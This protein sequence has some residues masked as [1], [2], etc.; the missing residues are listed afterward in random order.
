MAD[1]QV[2]PTTPPS[3]DTENPDAYPVI[4]LGTP[5]RDPVQI[6]LADDDS[7]SDETS[8]DGSFS[9]YSV[10]DNSVSV[11][12]HAPQP[13][14]TSHNSPSVLADREIPDS[15][16]ESPLGDE[17]TPRP[18]NTLGQP[19]SESSRRSTHSI[20][21][22]SISAERE[23]PDSQDESLW[24]DEEIPAPTN[25]LGRPYSEPDAHQ[26]I[27]SVDPR[28]VL[29]ERVIP[30]S[31]DESPWGDEG[32]PGPINTLGGPSSQPDSHQPIHSVDPHSVLA[33]RETPDVQDQ[34]PWGN[35]GETYGLNNTVEKTSLE[36]GFQ[37][38]TFI[39]HS[40]STPSERGHSRPPDTLDLSNTPLVLGSTQPVP[41]D[42]R[43]SHNTKRHE[44]RSSSTSPS[45]APKRLRLTQVVDVSDDGYDADLEDFAHDD[46]DLSVADGVEADEQGGSLGHGALESGPSSVGW[47]DDEE[48][49]F[50]SHSEYTP[51]GSSSDV[52]PQNDEAPLQLG[53]LSGADEQGSSADDDV[54]AGEQMLSGS[55]YTPSNASD[56]PQDEALSQPLPLSDIDIDIDVPNLVDADEQGF[57]STHAAR[58]SEAGSKIDHAGQEA[59]ATLSNRVC[60]PSNAL[61][62][63]NEDK[64]F[65]HPGPLSDAGVDAPGLADANELGS[66]SAQDIL[67]SG[68]AAKADCT[69]EEDEN[70]PSGSEFAPSDASDNDP[71]DDEDFLQGA[72]GLDPNDFDFEYLD[73][74]EDDNTT[75][76]IGEGAVQLGNFDVADASFVSCVWE[77][78]VPIDTSP[79]QRAINVNRFERAIFSMINFMT[80]W[81]RSVGTVE[82]FASI[83]GDN[84]PMAISCFRVLVHANPEILHR[85]V[86]E[87]ISEN[88]KEILGRS[89]LGVKDLHS[90]PVVDRDSKD[91]GCYLSV[92]HKE[93]ASDTT[94]FSSRGRD[95]FSFGTAM[96]SRSTLEVASDTTDLSTQGPVDFSFGTAMVSRSTLEVAS[97]TTD[98]STRG[99]ADF[100][101]GTAMVS[102]STLN[103]GVYAGSSYNKKGGIALRVSQHRLAIRQRRN[104]KVTKMNRGRHYDFAGRPGVSTRFFTI[105]RLPAGEQRNAALSVLI[106]GLTMAYLNTVGPPTGGFHRHDV[107]TFIND[108]RVGAFGRN[109][110]APTSASPNFVLFALNGAW[111][112]AQPYFPSQRITS[113]GCHVCGRTTK[114]MGLLNAGDV[115]GPRLCPAHFQEKRKLDPKWMS[116]GPCIRCHEPRGLTGQAFSGEGSNSMC[117]HCSATRRSQGA[118]FDVETYAQQHQG[119]QHCGVGEWDVVG[120]AKLVFHGLGEHRRCQACFFYRLE[121]RVERH[122]DLW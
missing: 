31:Q 39:D 2:A 51:T 5:I 26:P 46:G 50:Q 8:S 104:G 1:L 60:T 88:V 30:D 10:S 73:S 121:H 83:Y 95:D 24:A 87:S 81:C 18:A 108:M 67:E 44:R 106:E 113:A 101:F 32:T 28:S 54:E 85:N 84:G 118:A 111:C 42:R 25:T 89:S 72:D 110:D 68:R 62:E 59:E 76:H 48:A 58:E 100:S 69:D 9:D 66:S 80:T 52:D 96:V 93:V 19:S 27:H 43:T 6:L 12:I 7:F 119:C 105:A 97:D 38:T 35:N 114:R 15:Q 116:G 82:N 20:G 11:E 4:I 122:P 45:P 99:P 49:K 37:Q 33:E 47:V 14:Y 53:P 55:E 90:L 91:W 36:P 41:E 75:G 98:L 70:M 78:A 65:V 109:N 77:E 79:E 16:D 29:V 3:S 107:V 40:P 86:V 22:P 115:L 120:S 117:S 13:T 23:V 56:D 64:D 71:L 17:D 57:S 34:S 74:G 63:L 92:S 102:R 94:D 112:L 103:T 21:L 61:D